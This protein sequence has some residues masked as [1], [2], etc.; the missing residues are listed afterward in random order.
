MTTPAVL[1]GFA[2]L[3]AHVQD[4]IPAAAMIK[5]C[6]FERVAMEVRG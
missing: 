1:V 6:D 5:R 4:A 3:V 2:I